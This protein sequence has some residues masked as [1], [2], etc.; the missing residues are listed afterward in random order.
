MKPIQSDGFL[1]TLIS[2]KDFD[3][4]HSLQ[5]ALDDKVIYEDWVGRKKVLYY[6]IDGKKGAFLVRRDGPMRFKVDRFSRWWFEVHQ[7]HFKGQDVIYIKM[8]DGEEVK[9]EREERMRLD[10]DG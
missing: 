3:K 4:A 10:I 1:T 7:D 6:L 2:D 9:K 8:M 5:M